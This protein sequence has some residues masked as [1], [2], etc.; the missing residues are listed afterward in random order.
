MLRAVE[1]LDKI[2]FEVDWDDAVI[3]AT[4]ERLEINE[5]YSNDRHFNKILGIKRVFDE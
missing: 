2:N 3:A 5:I 1:I 4:M